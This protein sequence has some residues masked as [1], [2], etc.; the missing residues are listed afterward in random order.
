M[1]EL[2][3]KAEMRAWARAQRAQGYTVGLVPTMGFL[4]RGHMD[5]VALAQR[6]ADVVVVSIYVN[7]T[8]FAAGEDF[9]VYPSSLDSDRRCAYW[10]AALAPECRCQVCKHA[11]RVPGAA[12]QDAA[13]RWRVGA[14]PTAH[15][16]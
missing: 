2:H 3:N 16:V 1:H 11:R 15:P 14:L 10:R 12:V 9:D 4:H 6:E 13:R 8:Q 7:P 5:L